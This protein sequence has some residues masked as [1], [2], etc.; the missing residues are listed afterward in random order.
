M[1]TWKK[2]EDRYNFTGTKPITQQAA[3][4]N[5]KEANTAFT[6]LAFRHTALLLRRAQCHITPT[7]LNASAA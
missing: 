4:K 5:N 7:T 6:K 3:S 1:R 2:S